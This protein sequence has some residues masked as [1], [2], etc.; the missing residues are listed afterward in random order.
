[1]VIQVNGGK[2][3]NDY[4]TFTALL[5]VFFLLIPLV[6]GG[7]LSEDTK[8]ITTGS[9]GGSTGTQSTLKAD[10]AACSAANECTNS[11]CVHSICRSASTFCGDAFC[12]SGESCSSDDS[13]CAS[14]E[15]CTSG[16]VKKAVA[17]AAP[18]PSGGGAVT[19]TPKKEEPK[20]E[21]KAPEPTKVVTVDVPVTET[22]TVQEVV[23]AIKPS[24]LG[25]TEIKIENVE[26]KKVGIAEATTTT[27]APVLEKVVESALTIATQEPAKQALNEIKQAVSSGSSSPVSVSTTVEVFEVKEKTTGKTAFA[28]KVTLTLKPD[29]DLKDVNIVEV[30]P[31]S[32]A[33]SIL[34]VIFLGEQPKVLQADPIVQWEFSEVKKDETK[35]LS[36]QVPKKIE[37]IES[38]TI[39]VA[40]AVAPEVKPEIKVSLTAIYII[41]GIVAG[42]AILYIL[43][44]KFSRGS[45]GKPK[46]FK[47]NYKPR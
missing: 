42:I 39:A 46:Q 2:A 7:P 20:A 35:D 12:D 40:E 47:Y 30:I 16:C 29:N 11:F 6:I 36:Y 25:V 32:V 9:A 15:A 3:V 37:K 26:V 8:T 17:A 13:A 34:D 10:G 14:G 38:Q 22:K 5:V 31:K 18:A 19:P 27:Q 23:T 1:M 43:Y 45:P 41:V 44:K 28:S 4:K 33:A 24:D 21:E